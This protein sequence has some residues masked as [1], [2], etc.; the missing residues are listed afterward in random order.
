MS[1]WPVLA[2]SVIDFNDAVILGFLFHLAARQ[3]NAS[4]AAL[5]FS[6]SAG[7]TGVSASAQALLDQRSSARHQDSLHSAHPPLLRPSYPLPTINTGP[8]HCWNREAVVARGLATD[9]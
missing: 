9:S 6:P 1:Y 5:I 2:L 8:P 3:P 4:K 7:V